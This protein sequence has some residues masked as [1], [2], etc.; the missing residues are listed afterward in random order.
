MIPSIAIIINNSIKHQS[1]VYKR[2]NIQTIVFQT[3]QFSISA[4]FKCQ[5]FLLDPLIGFYLALAF[6]TRVD[7][8]AVTVIWYSAFPNAPALLMTCYHIV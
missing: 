3:I 8:E 2:L 1:F 7:L 5:T 4:E 6:W